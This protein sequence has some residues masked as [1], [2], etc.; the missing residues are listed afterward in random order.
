MM[1]LM[2]VMAVIMV[3]SMAMKVVTPRSMIPLVRA[4]TCYYSLGVD[5]TVTLSYPYLLEWHGAIYEY[6]RGLPLLRFAFLLTLSLSPYSFVPSYLCVYGGVADVGYEQIGGSGDEDGTNNGMLSPRLMA[7]INADSD[8]PVPARRNNKAALPSPHGSPQAPRSRD[9][10][11]RNGII[12]GFFQKINIFS[13]DKKDAKEPPRG[14]P[15]LV[16]NTCLIL[17][18]FC[19]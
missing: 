1:V 12:S 19:C 10:P 5:C 18:L 13:S 2:W 14:E 3:T 11:P 8:A 4:P 15:R 16:H 6:L 7:H 17:F 9:G